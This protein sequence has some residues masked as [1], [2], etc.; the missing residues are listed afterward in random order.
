MP[1]RAEWHWPPRKPAPILWL[2]L[3]HLEVDTMERHER[4]T[5]PVALFLGGLLVLVG[6]YHVLRNNLGI[7]LG[8]LDGD[9][10]WP[11]VVLIF[12]LLLIARSVQRSQTGG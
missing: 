11:S 8:P 3:T 6:G 12:G 9:L 7:E 5:G 4:F 10:I 2:E 1:D